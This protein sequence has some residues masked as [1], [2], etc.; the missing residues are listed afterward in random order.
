MVK[1]WALVAVL[2]FTGTLWLDR[3]PNRCYHYYQAC[4]HLRRLQTCTRLGLPLAAAVHRLK[5]SDCAC[6]LVAADVAMKRDGQDHGGVVIA[7]LRPS[8]LLT[9]AFHDWYA[10]GRL[11]MQVCVSAT[12]VPCLVYACFW[13]A[14]VR[15]C[16][17]W[18]GLGPHTNACHLM[19]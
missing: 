11:L 4:W 12:H 10:Q 7:W 13:V 6:A 19:L 3:Q 5:T 9:G 2:N 14:M 15:W 16:A 17:I 8:P 1:P 18:I